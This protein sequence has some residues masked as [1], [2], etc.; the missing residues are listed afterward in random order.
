MKAHTKELL[1]I[2]IFYLA[3]LIVVDFL[4]RAYPVLT[5]L[6]LAVAFTI[7]SIFILGTLTELT[8]KKAAR[9]GRIEQR[10]EDPLTYLAKLTKSALEEGSQDAVTL[11]SERLRSMLLSAVAYRINVPV[12]QLIDMAQ[13]HLDL[14]EERLQDPGIVTALTSAEPLTTPAETRRL[15]DLLLKV[16]SWLV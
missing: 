15:Q 14:L 5:W 13:N 8:P 7:F 9:P 11:L 4:L 1:E 10:S 6:A 2:A 3:V 12:A 16:E